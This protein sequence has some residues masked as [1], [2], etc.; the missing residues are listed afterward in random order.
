MS[1]TQEPSLAS[2]RAAAVEVLRRAE[3]TRPDVLLVRYND[4]L[5]VLKDYSE[6]HG[7]VPHW[8]GAWA[9]H[10][11]ARALKA[12][13]DVAGIPRFLAQPGPYSL[14]ISYT[15]SRPIRKIKRGMLPVEYIDALDRIIAAI[16]AHDIAHC[17]LRSRGN[18]LITPEGQPFVVDFAAHLR[19]GAGWNPFRLWLFNRFC[20]A[21]RVAAAR[22]RLRHAR[23]TLNP[24]QVAGLATDRKSLGERNIRHLS[25]TLRTLGRWLLTGQRDRPD[26]R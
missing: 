22:V 19:R 4:G 2:L 8:I 7:L 20:E 26:T 10:R 3:G 18:V 6:A 13:V 16:H 15:A 23:E 1:S 12:L 24:E 9:I 14:L 17:D 21:D 25:R 11:E 5:A